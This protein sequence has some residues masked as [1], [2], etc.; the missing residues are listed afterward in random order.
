MNQAVRNAAGILLVAAATLGGC[1]PKPPDP[2]QDSLS[3]EETEHVFERDVARITAFADSIERLLWPVPLMTSR[4]AAALRRFQNDDHLEVARSVGVPQ[5][6][7]QAALDIFVQSG[8]LVPLQDSRFWAIR[9]LDHSMPFVVPQMVGLLNE[10][11]TRFHARLEERGLPPI[12]FEITSVLRTEEDQQRLRRRNRN[13]TRGTSTHQFG[14]TL[15]ITYAG[16]R[17]PLKPVLTL[18]TVDAPWLE[19][20]LRRMEAFAIEVGTARVARE[21]QSILGAV[22]RELQDEGRVMVTMERRQPVFHITATAD[23]QGAPAAVVAP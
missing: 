10:M 14:T 13:A 22:L 9:D 18:D 6:V 21:L 15:D 16:Y 11:G 2:A 17:A 5:P 8:R 3:P 20:G 1:Q 7:T 23:G 4:Q 12:R 19:S